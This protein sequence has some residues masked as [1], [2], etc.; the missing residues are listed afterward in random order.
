[1]KK[2]PTLFFI[3]AFLCLGPHLVWAAQ[4]YVLIEKVG[5]VVEGEE[6][7]H[8][9]VGDVVAISPVTE[10][11][12]PT[13]AELDRYHVV[14]VDLTEAERDLL[15]KPVI[16]IVQDEFRGSREVV[17]KARERTVDYKSF[18]NQKQEAVINKA[19][20]LSVVTVKQ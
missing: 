18:R 1:M 14:I 8:T 4:Y 20:L 2:F 6:V 3:L 11:Y 7:G 17:I 10:Q 13:R 9:Q 5:M 19:D 12:Q 16:E 15:R